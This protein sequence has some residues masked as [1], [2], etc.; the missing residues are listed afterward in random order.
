M[1]TKANWNVVSQLVLL[2][3]P[4]AAGIRQVFVRY[5]SGIRQVFTRYTGKE[6]SHRKYANLL[7]G[8]FGIHPTSTTPKKLH[9]WGMDYGA[10]KTSV[11]WSVLWW[12]NTNTLAPKDG[13]DQKLVLPSDN[14]YTDKETKSLFLL[15]ITEVEWEEGRQYQSE[16]KFFAVIA[17]KLK[18]FSLK[19][20]LKYSKNCLTFEAKIH[21]KEY[22]LSTLAEWVKTTCPAE[23]TKL[24]VCY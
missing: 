13:L 10:S 2:N 16:C 18:N 8:P 19:T 5:L 24:R 9:S 21:V 17:R 6:T 12:A 22:V 7:N 23:Q 15:F 20:F 3:C 11:I 14:I 1:L 4:P